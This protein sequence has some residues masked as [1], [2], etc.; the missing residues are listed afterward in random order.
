MNRSDKI[1]SNKMYKNC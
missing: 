1:D